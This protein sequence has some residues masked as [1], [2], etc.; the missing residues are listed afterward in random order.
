MVYVSLNGHRNTPEVNRK[1]IH[2]DT[3]YTLLR[4]MYGNVYEIIDHDR[5]VRYRQ[6]HPIVDPGDLFDP[7]ALYLFIVITASSVQVLSAWFAISWFTI[8]WFVLT[9]TLNG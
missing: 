7:D 8:T 1:W 3:R 4:G 9:P 5:K 6:D 2:R